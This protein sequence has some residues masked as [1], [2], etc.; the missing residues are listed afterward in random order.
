MCEGWGGKGREEKGGGAGVTLYFLF[1]SLTW[2]LSV[3]KK[4]PG[5]LDSLVMVKAARGLDAATP[6]L[7]SETIPAAILLAIFNDDDG[8]GGRPNGWK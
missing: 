1:L 7:I 4:L 8:L 6:S 5:F 2:R 3:Y